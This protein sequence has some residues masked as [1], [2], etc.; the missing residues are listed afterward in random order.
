MTDASG[1]TW[2]LAAGSGNRAVA[3]LVP[4]NIKIIF[5][6]CAQIKRY[7]RLRFGTQNYE[8]RG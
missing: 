5:R 8:T 6:H 3:M 2:Q 7:T 4:T 1:A